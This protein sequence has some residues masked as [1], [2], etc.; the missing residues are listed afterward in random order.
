M[1]CNQH[2]RDMNR[3]PRGRR[4]ERR[5]VDDK[6]VRCGFVPEIMAQLHLDHIVAKMNGG[7]DEASNLQ[8]LCANCHALK[9]H[10]DWQAKRKRS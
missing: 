10:E 9:T 8:T 5:S 3:V 1:F 7:K 6:C 4:E 2:C